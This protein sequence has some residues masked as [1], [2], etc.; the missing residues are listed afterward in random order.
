[1][2]VEDQIDAH[3]L[4]RKI[5]RYMSICLASIFIGYVSIVIMIKA[6]IKNH[7][8]ESAGILLFV[9]GYISYILL[10]QQL[11]TAFEKNKGLNFIEVIFFPIGLIINYFSFRKKIKRMLVNSQS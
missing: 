2:T 5:Y 4:L 7:F 1:M 9:L 10:S 8:I 3:K 11:A 6:D